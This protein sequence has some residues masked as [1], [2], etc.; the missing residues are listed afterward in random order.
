MGISESDKSDI[1]KVITDMQEQ[2][3]QDKKTITK[4]ILD[5]IEILKKK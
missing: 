5:E 2:S 1:K 4:S 3:N